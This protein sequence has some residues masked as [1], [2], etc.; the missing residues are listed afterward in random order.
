MND[1][2][3]SDFK[4]TGATDYTLYPGAHNDRAGVGVNEI[5]LAGGVIEKIEVR[6]TAAA[7]MS[8]YDYRDRE[9]RPIAGGANSKRFQLTVTGGAAIRGPSGAEV[10]DCYSTNIPAAFTDENRVAVFELAANTSHRFEGEMRCYNG[11][12]IAIDAGGASTATV[13]ITFRPKVLGA[14]RKNH[15]D[16]GPFS[17]SFVPVHAEL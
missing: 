17:E 2:V 9:G 8:V 6:S 4:V 5:I 10:Y 12:A 11:M 16:K 14:V 1:Q 3:V 7:T 15:N 13:S